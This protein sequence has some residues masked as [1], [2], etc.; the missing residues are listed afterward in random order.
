MKTTESADGVDAMVTELIICR[1]QPARWLFA[2]LTRGT[3]SGKNNC[4]ILLA[5]RRSGVL[6]S[7]R[8]LRIYQTQPWRWR[9][10]RGRSFVPSN[11][12]PTVAAR[13]QQ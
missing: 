11:P 6:R 9:G 10:D 2:C 1:R 13:R 4:Q 12:K 8:D 3:N 5:G 7:I